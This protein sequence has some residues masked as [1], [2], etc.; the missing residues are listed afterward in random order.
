MKR[1]ICQDSELFEHRPFDF[2]NRENYREG[3]PND[4]D[5]DVFEDEQRDYEENREWYRSR[6]PQDIPNPNEDWVN[7][8]Q[9][10]QDRENEEQRFLENRG[11]DSFPTQGAGPYRDSQRF[12]DD[13]D[14]NRRRFSRDQFEDNERE[15]FLQYRQHRS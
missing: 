11:R 14:W 13:E 9:S 7:Y 8:E 12:T 5:I 1:E 6:K 15:Q 3:L 2:P 10:R 4:Q